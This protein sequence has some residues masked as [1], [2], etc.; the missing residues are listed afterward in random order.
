MDKYYYLISQLPSLV[1]DKST[2]MS[3][4][5]FLDEARKWMNPKDISLLSQ[6]NFKDTELNSKLPSDICNYQNFEKA[7]RLEIA[8][9]RKARKT[10]Q[11]FKPSLLPASTVKEG[12]PLE[13]EKK[14]LK[15]RWQFIDDMEKDHHFD[16]IFVMLYYLKLQILGRLMTFDKQKGMETFQK[17][18][19][20]TL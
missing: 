18:S 11:D 6:V 14:L 4:E 5:V 19:K 15:T 8:A 16:L 20:V 12:N 2:Y 1:F 17:V 10:G 3:A 7:I 9:W 13:V